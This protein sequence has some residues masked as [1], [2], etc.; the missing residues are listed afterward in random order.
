MR[1]SLP[2]FLLLLALV[3]TVFVYQP[4][5]P[6]PFLF[7]D[8]PNIL[9]N[10]KLAIQ[11]LNTDTLKQAAF[12][13]FSGPLLRP[14][15][16]MSFAVNRYATGLNPYYFKLTNLV[17]HLFNGAG[18]FI[19]T[20][21]LL[22]FYRK[23][24]EPDLSA[25]YAS[26]LSLAVASAWLLH[27]FNLTS[28]LYVV[29]RMTNLSAFFSIWGLA[30]FLWGRMRL[31]EGKSGIPLILSSLL[32]FTPLA[33]LS[34]ENGVLLPAFMLAMEVAL[35]GFHAEKP[36]AR[37][38]L[39]GFYALAVAVPAA[40]A[41]GYLAMHPDWLLAGY[42][43]R[44]FTLSERLMTEARVMWFY[45]W[46]ILLPSNA[47]MGLY[48]DDITISRSLFQPI[49]TVFSLVSMAALLGLSFAARK[50]APIV[51][52]GVL[53]FLAGHLLESTVWPL[54]IAHEH[55]NYLPMYGIVLI[56]FFYLLYPLKYLNN[57][58]LRQTVAMLLIGLFA[59]NTYARAGKWSNLYDL[60]QAE[61]EHHPNSALANGE[62]GAIYSK[63]VFL[64]PDGQ[65][66][67][68][69]AARLHFEKAAS[70]DRNDT[71][72]L[73]GLI[74]L[75][76]GIDKTA[77]PGWLTELMHRLEFSPYHAVSSDKLIVLTECQ[78][79]GYCRLEN[80]EWEGLLR[81]ALRNPTLTGSNRAKVLYAL[82]SYTINVVRD[83]PAALEIMHQ[84][85]KI[86]PHEVAYRFALIN[87]LVTLQ[88]IGEA[89]EQLALLKRLNT[90]QD[91]SVEIASLEQTLS[92]QDNN[93]SQH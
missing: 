80:A 60:F 88:R 18:I 41:L 54:E 50:K 49:S 15:S 81:A 44:D 62:M 79:K 27:P 71:K 57:L 24:F 25:T 1:R 72:P 63:I 77:E 74:M 52:F 34:K 12:S 92:M 68:Y 55:R 32:L 26:W 13:G 58:R 66:V 70:L 19:L 53:F 7:D 37:R 61:V 31:Y 83:Y 35:F 3:T 43:A 22:N 56:L 59:F 87:F 40:V 85:V 30:V 69:D 51:A 5:L 90:L 9:R 23:R 16:M 93:E 36:A 75:N 82:S 10:E 8:G 4:G 45:L 42:K 47:Q 91:Y 2:G 48:H 17:I 20:Q 11:N 78:I 33:A 86:A 64:G 21:L 14:V 39:A 29:Q 65:M 6:G 28:V 84:M 46:Q 67:N 73:F 38:F 76:A 89:R